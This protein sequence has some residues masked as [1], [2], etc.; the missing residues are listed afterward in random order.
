MEEIC[1]KYSIPIFN[2]AKKSGI[3][4]WDEA[5]RKLYFQSPNDTAH[6]NDMGHN[7]FMNKGEK[8]LLG[9]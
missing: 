7:L 1:A 4:V 3:Y 9:L 6:L 5:F 8:F 2:A